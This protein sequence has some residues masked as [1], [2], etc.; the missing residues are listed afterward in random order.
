MKQIKKKSLIP[1]LVC[2]TY[3][4]SHHFILTS[5]KAFYKINRNENL[6]Y[7]CVL[8]P[9]LCPKFLKDTQHCVLGILS[10]DYAYYNFTSDNKRKIDKIKKNDFPCLTEKETAHKG[11]QMHVSVLPTSAST[12]QDCPCSRLPSLI[13]SR[14]FLTV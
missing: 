5:K 2:F 11:M 13:W 7:Q 4:K 6:Q 12:R 9:I 10:L 3:E 14:G 8:S 1:R